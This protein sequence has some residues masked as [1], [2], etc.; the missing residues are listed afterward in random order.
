MNYFFSV[1]SGMIQ[2][3]TEFLPVS[4][5]GHLVILHEVFSF[6]LPNDLLFDLMLHWGTLLAILIFFWKDI[7]QVINGFFSSLIKWNVQGDNNQRLA[8][9]IILATIPAASIGFVFGQKIEDSVRSVPVVAVMFILIAGLFWL[10]EKYSTKLKTLNEMPFWS[11]LGIGVAQVLAF[12]PGTSRSGITII[13]G[14]WLKLKREEAARFSFLLSAPLIFGAGVK[15][16][17][18]VKLIT[19]DNALLMLIGLVTS[20][21]VGYI[22]I[23]F[24]LKYLTTHSLGVFAWYRLVLGVAVLAWWLIK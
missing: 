1:L 21:V 12:I 7:W 14:L 24:L 3:L 6:D 5:S 20:A 13:T 19:A 9:Q 15:Q 4:S 8:W 23:K 18:A 17:S 22:V 2:G 10:A 11:A 16:L